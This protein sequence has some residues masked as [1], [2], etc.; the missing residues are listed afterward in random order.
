[1]PL[2][3]IIAPGPRPAKSTSQATGPTGQIE[4]GLGGLGALGIGGQK[5][6]TTVNVYRGSSAGKFLGGLPQPPRETLIV[7]RRSRQHAAHYFMLSGNDDA[8]GVMANM[9]LTLHPWQLYFT[10]AIALGVVNAVVGGAAVAIAVG[11]AFD[12]S[13]GVAAVAGAAVALAGLAAA[14]RYQHMRR[15]SGTPTRSSS[16]TGRVVLGIES[17]NGASWSSP[18][19]VAI[20]TSVLDPEPM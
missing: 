9:G 7:G 17:G 6:P 16:R 20:R 3:S 2:G 11:V 13:L 18:L 5:M 1:M 8:R 15:E 4:P 14:V 12:T 10:A 19:H